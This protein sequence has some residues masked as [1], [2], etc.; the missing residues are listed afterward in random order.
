MIWTRIVTK[1]AR[2]K[3]SSHWWMTVSCKIFITFF[4]EWKS[5]NYKNTDGVVST[6]SSCLQNLSSSISRIKHFWQNKQRITSWS[7]H[8]HS[9]KISWLVARWSSTDIRGPQNHG[10]TVKSAR[11]NA[12]A[13]KQCGSIA[14]RPIESGRP[15]RPPVTFTALFGKLRYS[16]TAL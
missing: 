6:I 15:R 3:F 5:F 4:T 9:N 16:C 11:A 2:M 10:F 1:L 13:Q 12:R 14:L 7:A 8:T